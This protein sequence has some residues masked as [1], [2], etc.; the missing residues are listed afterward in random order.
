MPEFN[1]HDVRARGRQIVVQII[2]ARAIIYFIFIAI[3]WDV[4]RQDISWN[5]LA[6]KYRTEMGSPL[7]KYLTSKFLPGS[8]DPPAFWDYSMD[9]PPWKAVG[10]DNPHHMNPNHRSMIPTRQTS[11]QSLS[12]PCLWN[13]KE[14]AGLIISFSKV[15]RFNWPKQSRLRK[16]TRWQDKISE[17]ELKRVWGYFVFKL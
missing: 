11:W 10:I 5:P 2:E 15:Q 1:R 4:R 6:N 3:P 12:K 8:L 14:G 9:E 7:P 17:T 16:I 13:I